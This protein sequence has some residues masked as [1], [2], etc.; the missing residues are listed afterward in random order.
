MTKPPPMLII[1][2]TIAAIASPLTNFEAPSIAPKKS[3]SRCTFSRRRFASASE[4]APWLRS[5]SIAICFPGIASSV[6][7]AETS[8]TRS[9][10]LV[11]TMKLTMTRITNT[12][13]PTTALPPTTKL[14][15]AV[16]T[17]PA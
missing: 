5:A 6:N 10:P 13:K 7:R 9:D 11:M 1:M 12:M 14:P 2:M 17:S 16:M 3:D 15:N 4:I 8:A